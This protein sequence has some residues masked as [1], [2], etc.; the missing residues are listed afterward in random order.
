[1]TCRVAPFSMHRVGHLAGGL[2]LP[3]LKLTRWVAPAVSVLLHLLL[4]MAWVAEP[5][6]TRSAQGSA[7]LVMDVLMVS[8]SVLEPSAIPVPAVPAPMPAARATAS[9][10]TRRYQPRPVVAATPMPIP[11]TASDEVQQHVSAVPARVASPP[12]SLDAKVEPVWVSVP[13]FSSPPQYPTYP[14]LARKRGQQGTVWLEIWLSEQGAQLKRTL[15]RSSGFALL[16]EAAL[17]AAARWQFEPH[18]HNG[19]AVASRVR[20]P[21]EFAVR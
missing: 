17:R 16:D 6:E 3:V 7:P 5:E 21:I 2:V 12:K 8:D 14:P 19:M 20:I 10:V 11:R 9:P 1:M 15:S 13:T 18:R 4:V